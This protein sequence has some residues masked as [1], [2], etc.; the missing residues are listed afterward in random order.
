[1]TLTDEEKTNI[2]TVAKEVFDGDLKLAAAAHVHGVGVVLKVGKQ[3]AGWFNK[4]KINAIVKLL[5][6]P[7]KPEAPKKT[8]KKKR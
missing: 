8:A 6:P 3:L 5:S 1:M 4:K 2:K 7:I